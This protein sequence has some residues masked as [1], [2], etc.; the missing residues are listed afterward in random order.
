MIYP[1]IDATTF[2]ILAIFMWHGDALRYVHNNHNTLTVPFNAGKHLEIA[3][4][5]YAG[6][7]YIKH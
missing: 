1:V 2:V 3:R 5:L 6:E 4:T 7:K